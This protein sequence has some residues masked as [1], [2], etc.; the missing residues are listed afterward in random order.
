[1]GWKATLLE[2]SLDPWLAVEPDA[3][4]RSAVLRF[5]IEL[6]PKGA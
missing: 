6:T 3:I 2:D 4:R 5:L 1:V